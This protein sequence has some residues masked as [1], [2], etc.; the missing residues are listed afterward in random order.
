MTE[1]K[2]KKLKSLIGFLSAWQLK[3]CRDTTVSAA[4]VM[5]LSESFFRACCSWQSEGLFGQSFS[6]VPSIQAHRGL[7]C[8]GSYSVDR[9]FRH[10]KGPPGWGP[11]CSSVCQA[12]DGPASI[13]QLQ[14]LTC[15]GRQA[16][17]TVTASPPMTLSCIALLPWLPGFPPQAFPTTVS[18]LTSPPSV[19]LQSTAA[20]ALG[21]LHTPQTPAPS[22]CAFQRTSSCPGHVWL[23]QGLSD[24]HSI[25]AV[26]DQLF[27]SQP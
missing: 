17:V 20:L 12:F 2:E 4:G 7:P 21:L 10:L 1:G 16:T 19:S 23:Q 25:H 9:H 27:P 22:H 3:V 18:S 6:V 26:T 5:A 13:L 14:M 8:L 11:I 15:W 24:S